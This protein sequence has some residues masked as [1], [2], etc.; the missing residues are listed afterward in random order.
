MI[1]TLLVS[2]TIGVTPVANLPLPQAID[3][4][5]CGYLRKVFPEVN[6]DAWPTCRICP[7]GQQLYIISNDGKVACMKEGRRKP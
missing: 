1:S 5:A 6:V 3:P 2:I 4:N 7:E